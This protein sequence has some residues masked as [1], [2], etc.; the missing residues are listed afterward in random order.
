MPSPLNAARSISARMLHGAVWMVLFRLL[1][2]GLG[3]ISTLILVR[4]LAPADFG[5]VAMAMS[6]IALGE[7]LSGFGFD[8][9][10][11]HKQDADRHHYDA[12]WTCNLLLGLGVAVVMLVA[13]RPI[14]DFYEQP[15][16]LLVVVALAFG[17]A[18]GGFENIGVVAFRKELEFRREFGFLLSK[19]LV[20]FAITVPLAFWLQNYWALVLGTLA[21]RLAGT[22]LSYC[23]HAFRPR[24]SR[25]AAPELFHFSKWMLASNILA[26]LKERSSDFILGRMRGLSELG[27]YNV[28]YEFANLPTSELSAPINRALLPGFARIARQSA[29]LCTAYTNAIGVLALAALPASAGIYAL[30]DYIVP[31]VLGRKWS[32]ALYLMEVLALYGGVQMLHSST[33]AVI[34]ATGH[35]RNVARAN[36]AYVV[37]LIALML[38]FVPAWGALGASFAI[39]ATTLVSTPAYLYE[40][41]IST[42]I[43]ATTFVRAVA[44]PLLAAVAMC[45]V[46][47]WLVPAYTPTLDTL[48]A[49]AILLA[50]IVLGASVYI[51]FMVLL[52]ITSGRPDG[53]ERLVVERVR[54][55]FM[56]Y[57]RRRDTV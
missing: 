12:A 49:T 47:R 22:V 25:A 37:M 44:R 30:S 55:A 8:I 39:L 17:P 6:F 36:A 29:P 41:R 53:A 24:F 45:G 2:R 57:L 18:I 38:A 1:E 40:L 32:A 28:S 7:L 26:F 43:P 5:M 21:S 34:I 10:L 54:S 19:K 3:L 46:L 13:A 9:A 31:V 4:L 50:G 11:I 48:Q 15:E 52:W 56:Q 16:L 23:V 14:A 27:L 51:A 20:G 42:G 35:P 33:C